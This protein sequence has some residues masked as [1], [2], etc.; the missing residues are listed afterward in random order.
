MTLARKLKRKKQP[1]TPRCPK[2]HRK[3]TYYEYKGVW[4]CENTDCGYA[5]WNGW[6]CVKRSGRKSRQGVDGHDED[7]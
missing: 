2:C 7:I 3:L 6:N 5:K 4:M 1:K